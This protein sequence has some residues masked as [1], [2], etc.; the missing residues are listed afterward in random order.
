MEEVIRLK[1]SLWYVLRE[2]RSR[3]KRVLSLIAVSAAILSVMILVVLWEEAAWRADVMPQRQENYH[4]SF[5]NLTEADKDYI[6]KQEFVQITYDLYH[7]A[8][9]PTYANTFRVRV[10]KEYWHRSLACAE[11][12]LM[13][14][15]LLSRAPYAKIYNADYKDQYQKLLDRWYGAKVK[16]GVRIEDASALN[17]RGFVLIQ[18]VQ[19]SSYTMR[20]QNGYIMQPAFLSF[21]FVLALFL[22]A[23]ILILALE[24]YRANVKEYGCLRALG[25]KKEQIF[26]V[27]L[28][29]SL[30]VNLLAIPIASLATYGAVHLYYLLTDKYT[31][32]ANDIYFT[33]ANYIPLT[34]LS[35]LSLYLIVTAL[36]SIA[37]SC[38]M[39]RKKGVMSLLRG[40]DTFHIPFVAKTSP[41]FENA[42]GIGVY[43]RLYG[44]RARASLVRFTLIVAIMLPLPTS[45]LLQGV[46]MLT[47]PDTPS[48]IVQ[49]IY[50]AFQITAVLITTL[51]VTYSA[52]R[53]LA[54]SRAQELSVIRALGGSRQTIRRV[55]YPIAAVQAGSILVLSLFVNAAISRFF[56]TG[57]YIGSTEGARAVSELA[58]VVIVYAVSTAVFVI[59][60][61]YS[62]LLS[63]LHSFFRKPIITSIR[64]TE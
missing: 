44:L 53:M 55:T 23:A 33:I 31:S 51:S 16:N 24:M 57:N 52:S 43:A 58:G 4:F 59:P 30:L 64:E 41:Q 26:F 35:L 1:V 46:S 12:I 27:N 48:H 45:Y 25:L 62:G 49:A 7:N 8:E 56:S 54:Q 10:K 15:G 22:G 18:Y 50:S 5:Y 20:T 63:F 39:Y 28:W 47:I 21:L 61:A 60:S 9:D 32:N 19:N 36:G 14:R 38:F 34:V 13:A 40:E 3:P 42:R 11:E 37:L 17:A 2:F 29:E 6:R